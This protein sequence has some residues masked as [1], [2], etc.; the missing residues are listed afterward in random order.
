MAAKTRSG[1]KRSA[2]Q[3]GERFKAIEGRPA[4][5]APRN[6]GELGGEASRKPHLPAADP[7]E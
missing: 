6:S 3:L 4:E 7:D 5:A 1:L 2:E